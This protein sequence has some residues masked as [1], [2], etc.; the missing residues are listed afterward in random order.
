MTISQLFKENDASASVDWMTKRSFQSDGVSLDQP[1]KDFALIMSD[2]DVTEGKSNEVDASPGKTDEGEIDLT[3]SSE[4]QNMMQSSVSLL[5]EDAVTPLLTS[6][7]F[8]QPTIGMPTDK[9]L[10]TADVENSVKKLTLDKKAMAVKNLVS[11]EGLQEIKVKEP[12]E[13]SIQYGQFSWDVLNEKFIVSDQQPNVPVETP[14]ISLK[15]FF[16]A[17]EFKNKE[18]MEALGGQTKAASLRNSGDLTLHSVLEP[19]EEASIIVNDDL[20]LSEGLATNPKLVTDEKLA[21]L[22]GAPRSVPIRNSGDLTL[23]SVLG[24]GD[25]ASITVNDDLSLS[26][27]SA[28]SAKLLKDEKLLLG[29]SG[30]PRSVPIRNPGDLTLHSVLT[31]GDEASVAENDD[32]SLSEGVASNA[33]LVKDEKLSG[34]SGAPRSVSIRNPGD[35]TLHSVLGSGD[36]VTVPENDDLSLSEGVTSTAKS[37]KEEKTLSA[38]SGATRSVPIRNPGDLIV[39]S[40]SASDNAASSAINDVDLPLSEGDQENAKLN[41]DGKLIN[42]F[43]SAK[44]ISE[45][46]SKSR[47]SSLQG[48]SVGQV[49]APIGP[50]IKMIPLR[51]QTA[52]LQMSPIDASAIFSNIEISNAGSGMQS[53]T[54][55]TQTGAGTSGQGAMTP[56][57]LLAVALDVRQQGW[58]KALVNRVINTA[59]SGRTLTVNILPAHLGKITLKLSEGRRGTDLRI[60]ADVPATASM[61]RDVQQQISSAFDNAGLTLGEYSAGTGKGGSEGSDPRENNITEPE[62][63]IEDLSDTG[64]GAIGASVLDEKS[65]INIL[66]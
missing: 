4:G 59:Q 35:L 36:E 21:G 18:L 5:K 41:N 24:L 32:L 58:T 8:L 66:L 47:T 7:E 50:G 25:E 33:K 43:E 20:S 45:I 54:G 40:V 37:V 26:E 55:G 13:T 60:V 10:H 56:H 38:L 30:A 3:N 64:L 23:H 49:V 19:G 9:S 31:S 16:G 48:N 15:P 51:Q 28:Y 17:T 29:L 57:Q 63:E 22:S 61:L 62:S 52:N 14:D 39:Q 12:M 53:Q 42:N 2:F 34:L 46:I 1:V 65:H 27:G 6:S 11:V 44:S